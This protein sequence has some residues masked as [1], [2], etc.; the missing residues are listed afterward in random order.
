MLEVGDGF[1]VCVFAV[2]A[3]RIISIFTRVQVKICRRRCCKLIRVKSFGEGENLL[4]SPI[5]RG[6]LPYA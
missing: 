2:I 1:S 3:M 6:L 4:V 5:C